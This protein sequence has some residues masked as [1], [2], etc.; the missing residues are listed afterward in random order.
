MVAEST[1]PTFPVYEP[2]DPKFCRFH[3]L[4]LEVI[5]VFG[6]ALVSEKV[7][8][9]YPKRLFDT[10]RKQNNRTGQCGYSVSTQSLHQCGADRLGMTRA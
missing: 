5:S 3:L 2:T 6:C 9:K 8:R 4:K 10:V 7:Q 1:E